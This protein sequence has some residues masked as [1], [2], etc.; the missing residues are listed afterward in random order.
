MWDD[1]SRLDGL[2]LS[3]PNLHNSLAIYILS[4]LKNTRAQ[5][6]EYQNT[7]KKQLLKYQ[8]T[9]K[10]KYTHLPVWILSQ[11]CDMPL[12]AILYHKQFTKIR[13]VVV[14]NQHKSRVMWHCN[15]WG[16]PLPTPDNILTEYYSPFVQG[17]TFN[18]HPIISL[19][20]WWSLTNHERVS[21]QIQE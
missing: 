20:I 3:S 4:R 17:L 6:L 7:H 16:C 21:Q 14:L 18:V 13:N 9:Q 10:Q 11:L 2:D 12:S 15:K 5:I 8:S 1:T 19:L